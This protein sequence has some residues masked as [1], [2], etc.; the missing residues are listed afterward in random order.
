MLCASTCDFWTQGLEAIRSY[1]NV[2]LYDFSRSINHKEPLKSQYFAIF[3]KRENRL[4]F[5]SRRGMETT[6][7]LK[8]CR[9]AIF[10]KNDVLRPGSFVVRED[11]EEGVSPNLPFFIRRTV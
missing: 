11:G 5:R 10:E 4:P 9:I 1:E 2:Y 6:F 3:E 7:G 8:R